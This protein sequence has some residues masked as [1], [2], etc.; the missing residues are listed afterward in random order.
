MKRSKAAGLD[1]LMVE[2]VLYS[3]PVL[4][5]ILAKMFAATFHMDADL[6]K[7]YPLQR[8]YLM[9]RFTLLRITGQFLLVLFCQKIFEHYNLIRYRKFLDLPVPTSL[10]SKV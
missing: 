4:T 9:L 1:D 2:H 7:R 5:V 10:A 8:K 6:A 3:H